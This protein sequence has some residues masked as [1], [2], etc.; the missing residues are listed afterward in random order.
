[1]IPNKEKIQKNKIYYRKIKQ[2]TDENLFH[3]PLWFD[4]IVGGY[5]SRNNTSRN[6]TS[7]SDAYNNLVAELSNSK[8]IKNILWLLSWSLRLCFIT[9]HPEWDNYQLF[10]NNGIANIAYFLYIHEIYKDRTLFDKV[11]ER[12]IPRIVPRNLYTVAT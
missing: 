12:F 11:L 2:Q 4:G 6:N 10:D 1:M 3:F 8:I 5:T 9:S 7:N